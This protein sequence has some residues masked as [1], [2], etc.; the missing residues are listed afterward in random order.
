MLDDN[1]YR[2][3]YKSNQGGEP[4]YW[5]PWPANNDSFSTLLDARNAQLQLAE[6]RPD[7]ESKIQVKQLPQPWQDLEEK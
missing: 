6:I 2:L 5:M 1:N 3:V 7:C 4:V